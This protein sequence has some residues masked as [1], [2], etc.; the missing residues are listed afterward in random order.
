ME[1][2]VDK[3]F[4]LAEDDVL[5]H[6]LNFGICSAMQ[7]FGIGQDEVLKIVRA[8]KKEIED[9]NICHCIEIADT[10]AIW[11]DGCTCDGNFKGRIK[12]PMED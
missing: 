8:F 7:R 1:I 6:T 3:S 5:E 9:Y 11:V 4:N 2:E 12:I 10:S